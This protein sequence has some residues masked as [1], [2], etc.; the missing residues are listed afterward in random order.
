MELLE[1]KKVENG[2]LVQFFIVTSHLKVY[3]VPCTALCTV[4]GLSQ[5]SRIR[6]QISG[7]QGSSVHIFF[8]DRNQ[9]LTTS[10]YSITSTLKK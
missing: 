6:Y 9:I 3:L 2:I 7:Y 5:I 1:G 10:K 4:S 8:P